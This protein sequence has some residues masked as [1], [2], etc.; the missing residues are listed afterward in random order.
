MTS[1]LLPLYHRL[2]PRMRSAAATLRGW[3]LNRWR[4]G[5]E[6]RALMQEARERD[7]WSAVDWQKWREERL[8]YVL[9]RAATSVPYYRDMWS[10]RRQRG[11]RSSWEILENWPI[12]EKDTL[13]ANPRRFVADDCDTRRMMHGE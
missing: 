5:P 7:G 13:R 1:R 9:R 4:Y 3:Y 6:S 10:A 12:L 11:D 2:P 8:A